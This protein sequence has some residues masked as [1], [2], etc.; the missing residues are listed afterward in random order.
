MK[1]K[2]GADFTV[3][4][5]AQIFDVSEKTVRSWIRDGRLE[6]WK[7]GK[8]AYRIRPEAVELFRAKRILGLKALLAGEEV[9]GD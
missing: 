6:A 9:D 1:K 5:V 2:C 7:P 4:D 8:R 3:R